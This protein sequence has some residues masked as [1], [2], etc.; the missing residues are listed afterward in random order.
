[1]GAAVE[2]H[3]HGAVAMAHHEDGLP[4]ELGGDVV[5]RARHL[6]GVAHEQPGAPEDALHFELENIGIGVDV[7]VNAS[8]TNQPGNAF[9]ISVAHRRGRNHSAAW[10]AWLCTSMLTSWS[11]EAVSSSMPQLLSQS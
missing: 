8:G 9:G 4:A 6:A 10:W 5:T 3:V 11:G 7:A 2:Q 1:M